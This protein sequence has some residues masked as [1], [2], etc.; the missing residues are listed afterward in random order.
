MFS[1]SQARDPARVMAQVRAWRRM[2]HSLD[3]LRPL[4]SVCRRTLQFAPCG[5]ILLPG[6][7]QGVEGRGGGYSGLRNASLR[8]SL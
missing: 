1:H 3:E 5:D 7:A 6:H 4:G 2:R 8:L